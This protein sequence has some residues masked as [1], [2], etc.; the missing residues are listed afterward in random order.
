MGLNYQGGH[1]EFNSLKPT[2]MGA[3]TQLYAGTTPESADLG[4]TAAPD[5]VGEAKETVD[6]ETGRRMWK[7]LEKEMK[8]I[9]YRP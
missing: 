5:T 2:A 3:L 9:G 6:P 4:G 8:D 1:D 7:W